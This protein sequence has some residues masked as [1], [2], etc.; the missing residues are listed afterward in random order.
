MSD[1]GE[2]Q[3]FPGHNTLYGFEWGPVEVKR[4]CSDPR[5]GVWLLLETPKQHLEIRV[6]RTGLFRVGKPRKRVTP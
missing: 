5:H 6:T 4:A 3:G 1:P 2:R